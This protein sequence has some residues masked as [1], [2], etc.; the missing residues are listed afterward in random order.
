MAQGG[1]Q[2]SGIGE[3]EMTTY[4]YGIYDT[5]GKGK[6]TYF[7]LGVAGTREEALRLAVKAAREKGTHLHYFYN[8]CGFMSR[9]R[10]YLNSPNALP[11]TVGVD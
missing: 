9:G 5:R 10:Y 2:E 6:Q 4:E 7:K 1:V 8:S 3:T 11:V